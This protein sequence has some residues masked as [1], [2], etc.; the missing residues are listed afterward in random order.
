[1]AKELTTQA[2]FLRSLKNTHPDLIGSV[3]WVDPVAGGL[4]R[5]Q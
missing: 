3:Y 1:L 5:R 2:N 4:T